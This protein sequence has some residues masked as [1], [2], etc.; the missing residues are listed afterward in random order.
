MDKSTNIKALL[1]L[2][3]EGQTTL[4]QEETLRIYFQQA[5]ISPELEV[6][7]P[8][9]Q[10]FVLE[11]E[12]TLDER[13]D[14]DVLHKINRTQRQGRIIKL[15]RWSVAVAACLLI[16]IGSWAILNHNQQNH[17]AKNRWAQYE[18]QNVEEAVKMT[19]AAFTKASIGL[20]LGAQK[21][22]TE[23]ELLKQILNK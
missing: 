18:P 12:S 2:Y 16:T 5:D 4:E 8:L 15:K 13:F 3:F 9:F 23:V 20:N 22:A 11:K 10:L 14:Q 6:Y 1:D 7:R 19:K 17:T 21:A